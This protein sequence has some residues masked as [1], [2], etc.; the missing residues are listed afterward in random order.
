MAERAALDF[1]SDKFDVSIL[2]PPMVLGENKQQLNSFADLNQSSI[3]IQQM[4]SG[5]QKHV[6]PGSM[7]FVDVADL[8]T[9][10]ILAAKTPAAGGQRYLCSG[11]TRTWL[12]VASLL[13]QIFPQFR[14]RIPTRCEHGTQGQPT[15]VLQND[16]IIAELGLDFK[17]LADTLQAQGEALIKAG[18]LN[19]I[20]AGL[21]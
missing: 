11:E 2:N 19:P 21:D 20:C 7:G 3:F 17:P 10:H 16:K 5:K 18:L 4:L 12:E 8:A 6:M 13:H 15:M 14:D 1:V 9:A